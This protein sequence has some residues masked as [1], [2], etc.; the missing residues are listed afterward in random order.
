VESGVG[1]EGGAVEEV[2]GDIGDPGGGKR[3]E[4][5]GNCDKEEGE[6]A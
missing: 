5:L 6:M 2:T 4:R 3:T 1:E